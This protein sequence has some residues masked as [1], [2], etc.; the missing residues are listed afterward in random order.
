VRPPDPRRLAAALRRFLLR[1]RGEV[2]ARLRAGAQQAPPLGHWARPM[3]EALGPLLAPYLV[4]GG[5]SALAR[6]SRL[7]SRRKAYEPL[8]IAFDL[9]NPHVAEAV[10][11]LVFDFCQETLATSTMR[12]HEAL[13]ALRTELAEGLD[14]GEALKRLSARVGEIFGDP[15][16]AFMIAAT[17]ASR[18]AHAGQL[19]AAEESGVVGGL[20]WLSSSDC[21]DACAALDGRVVRLGE[22]FTVTGGKAAYATVLHP[23]LH[24][25]CMCSTTEVLNEDL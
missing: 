3:A 2:L 12:V 24:P 17:E 4:A 23:P 16:R 18:A 15:Q 7:A 10:R 11:R 9:L 25:H 20:R 21:C 6:I 13:D 22:P 14:R 8:G 5:L 1:Q 19:L